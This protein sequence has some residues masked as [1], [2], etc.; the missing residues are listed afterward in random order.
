MS[1]TNYKIQ[2]VFLYI[3]LYAIKVSR[4]LIDNKLC[5]LSKCFTNVIIS[6]DIAETCTHET[7][8]EIQ[9]KILS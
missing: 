2:I 4:K 1:F 3:S 8:T 9:S 6:S 5:C 7:V